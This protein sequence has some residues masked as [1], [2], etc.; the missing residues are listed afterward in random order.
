MPDD[1]APAEATG[2]SA[3]TFKNLVTAP[4]R[5]VKLTYQDLKPVF[6]N[7]WAMLAIVA[8]IIAAQLTLLDRPIAASVHTTHSIAVYLAPQAGADHHVTKIVS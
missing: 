6:K 7:G 4:N 3:S 2:K 1:T 5:F 8:V